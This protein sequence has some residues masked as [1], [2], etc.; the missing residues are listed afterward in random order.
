MFLLSGV[1]AVLLD[2]VTVVVALVG[3]AIVVIC[4]CF[5]PLRRYY[6]DS[7]ARVAGRTIEWRRHEDI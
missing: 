3:V 4:I 2:I 7:A 1:S 6:C 5:S